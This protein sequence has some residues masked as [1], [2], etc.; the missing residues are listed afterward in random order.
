M[1]KELQEFVR[2]LMQPDVSSRLG[3]G[4]KEFEVRCLRSFY[5]ALPNAA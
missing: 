1:S 3:A 4:K 2:A 5:C